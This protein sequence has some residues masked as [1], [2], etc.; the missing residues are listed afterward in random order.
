MSQFKFTQQQIAI[1]AVGAI[2]VLALGAV[3][4][5]GGQKKGNPA[6]QAVTLNIWGTDSAKAFTDLIDYYTQLHPGSKIT[7]TKI[8]PANYDSQLL[9]AFAAGTGPD[10]F[11][12]SN[13]SLPKWQ[14]TL[15]PLPAAYAAQFGML[16]MQ[17]DFPS[18][19]TNDFTA[20]S[21]PTST[22]RNIY[23]LPLSVDTLAMF[24]NKGLLASAGIV[25]P[26]AT[27]DEFDVD[28]QKLRTLN[29]GGQIAHAAAAIGG[30][31]T[32][33]PVAPD[34]LSLLMLQNGTQMVSNDL[35]QADFA[36]SPDSPGSAA[37]NFYLQFANASS[38]YYTWS[39]SMGNDVQA[40]VN[41]Q[42]AIIFGYSD[43][44]QEIQAKSPFMN[45]GIASMPQP[46]GATVSVSYPKYNGLAVYKYS[47]AAAAAWQFILT[48]TTS[49]NGESIYTGATG[50]PPALLSE[51]ETDEN[52]PNLSVF[53]RQA[54][55]A[56]S[57]YEIDSAAVDTMLNDAIQNAENGTASSYQSLQQ[58]QAA[59]TNLM[60]Q[61]QQ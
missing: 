30:S 6:T 18:V 27:W 60:I 21:T 5:F 3:F 15:L 29:S 25:T 24:Y 16:Q 47:S 52:N 2:I 12:I 53:A 57:W 48:L 11:E 54:L 32:S 61:A 33:I 7:Y 19:V 22:T 41:G 51:I 10:I 17:N 38:P 9:R 42:V 26:P 43:T 28:I 31:E 20:S 23:A 46:A 50:A 1:L 58:A 35:S 44:L 59:L 37:F 36:Q 13:R 49:A 39:D 34:I 55:T 8:D 56:Q 14:P 45:V 4:Y 40:F